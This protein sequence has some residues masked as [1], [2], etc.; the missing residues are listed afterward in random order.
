MPLLIVAELIQFCNRRVVLAT[1]QGGGEENVTH[2]FIRLIQ[3]ATGKGD[4]KRAKPKDILS[5]NSK[6]N[7]ESLCVFAF[8]LFF[9]LFSRK[10]WPLLISK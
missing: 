4:S 1:E 9:F 7:L 5:F 2:I 3:F 8:V 6:S 10:N